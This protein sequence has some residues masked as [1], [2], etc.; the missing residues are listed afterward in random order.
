MIIDGE[1]IG[2]R[3]MDYAVRSDTFK[4]YIDWGDGILT[5]FL[6]EDNLKIYRLK[7]EH[8]YTDG[9]LFHNI[10]IYGRIPSISLYGFPIEIV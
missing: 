7:I 10:S 2:K 3:K 9:L 6:W 4:G 8:T 5:D 1:N